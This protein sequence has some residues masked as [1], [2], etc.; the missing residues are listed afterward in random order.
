MTS[1]WREGLAPTQREALKVWLERVLHDLVKYLELMPRNLDWEQLEED[2]LEVLYE[3]IFETR[4]DR[5]GARSASQVW[6]GALAELDPALA[7]SLPVRAGVEADLAVLERQRQA[8]EDGDLASFEAEATREA[9]F[10]VG[11]RLRG[12]RDQPGV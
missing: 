9:I 11:R 4:V 1:T 6:S 7:A 8:L 5:S 2:D 10:G 12:L 3:A